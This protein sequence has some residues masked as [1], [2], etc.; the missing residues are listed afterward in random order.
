MNADRWPQ[1]ESLYHAA[2]KVPHEERDAF[3]RENCLDSELRAE[4]ESLLRFASAPAGLLDQPAWHSRPEP[5]EQIGP[6]RVGGRIG[7]GGMG[8]VYRAADTK[9][10]RDVALKFLPPAY[11]ADPQWLA[12]F[13]REAR[14]LASLNHP[15]IAAIYG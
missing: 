11:A 5:G 14:I 12:R 13:Q 8:E 6:Y 3:L 9:L 1:A 7:A 4:V 15:H 10:H 2:L